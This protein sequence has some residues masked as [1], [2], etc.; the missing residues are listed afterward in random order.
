MKQQ[1][2]LLLII[3]TCGC[4]P[5]EKDQ[6]PK[7]LQ[8]LKNLT[9][10]SADAKSGKTISFKK[11]AVYENSEKVLIGKMGDLAVDSLGRVFIA[12][13]EKQLIHVFEPGGRFITQFG[14]EGKGPGEFSYIKKLQ[15]R[16]NLLY[17]TDSN[18]GTQKVHIFTL[19]TP[20]GDKTIELA[21]NR[22]NYKPL[23]KAYPGVHELY[24]RNN[25]TYLAKFISHGTNPTQRWQNKE[26]KGMLYS[27]DSTGKI[28]SHKLFEFTEEIRTY[29]RGLLPI[30]PFFGNAF[31]ALSSDNTIYW[32][33]S[34]FD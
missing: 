14:R 6:I 5:Q 31:T 21:R 29:H 4:T 10:Y 24:V 19:D 9:V 8:K 30:E 33:G 16:N 3:V 1:F 2:F 11:S 18:F 32:A 7:Q 27:L 22:S 25:G 34:F 26:I 28:V 23:A 20:A 17:A 15:I 13:V 12:D